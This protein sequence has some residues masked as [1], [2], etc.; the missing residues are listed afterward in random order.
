MAVNLFDSLF[1]IV[2][3]VNILVASMI[4]E[5]YYVPVAAAGLQYFSLLV[6]GVFIQDLPG[7]G[8]VAAG[9]S[10]SKVICLPLAVPVFGISLFAVEL[11]LSGF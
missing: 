10:P 2:D 7:Q 3:S 6:R 8:M 1:G 9:Y 11:E 5:I 4:N